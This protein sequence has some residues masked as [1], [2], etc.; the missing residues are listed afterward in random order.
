MTSI[1]QEE[2]PKNRSFTS[3]RKA[4]MKG[5]SS[6]YKLD[7]LL[8]IDGILRVGGRLK[9][10]T[11]SESIKFPTILPKKGHITNLFIK[12]CHEEVM[13]QGRGMTLNEVRSRGFWIIA[14][15]TAVATYILNCVTCRKLR[16]M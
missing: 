12:H 10:A 15:L 11:M 7:P 9:H 13:H 14:G 6:L 5:C 8:D 3:Q 4:V 1:S 16:G 2:D